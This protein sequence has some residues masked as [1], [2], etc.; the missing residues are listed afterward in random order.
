MATKI[1]AHNLHTDVK[2]ILDSKATTTQL[3]AKADISALAG[4]ADSDTVVAALANKLTA[5]EE[6]TFFGLRTRVAEAMMFDNSI[7][8]SGPYEY[9]DQQISHGI[10]DSAFDLI[11]YNMGDFQQGRGGNV[12]F[13]HPAA[14]YGATGKTH[15][16]IDKNDDFAVVTSGHVRLVEDSRSITLGADSDFTIT[17]DGTNNIINSIGPGDL[18]IQDAGVSKLALDASGIIVYG[19][20][21][22]VGD[23][24]VTGAI[25]STASG[26][27]TITSASNIIFNADSGN[28][29][30]NFSGSKIIN[31]ANPIDSQDAA[32][33]SYV[34]SANY[35]DSDVDT[36]LN[37][38][39]AT[40][41]E[42][43]SWSGTDYNWV[44]QSGGASGGSTTVNTIYVD[45]DIKML[46]TGAILTITPSGSGVDPYTGQTVTWPEQNRFEK[47]VETLSWGAG[48]YAMFFH[49]MI[50]PVPIYSNTN[51]LLSADIT[52]HIATYGINSANSGYDSDFADSQ[53]IQGHLMHNHTTATFT[54]TSNV[55]TDPGVNLINLST[56]ISS[57]GVSLDFQMAQEKLTR[58]TVHS[59]AAMQLNNV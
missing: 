45:S 51:K 19:S 14:G 7:W 38:S 11:F 15:L 36:H 52:I 35:K 3:A 9:F 22:V 30:I 49:G 5:V 55:C 1:K 12:R 50:N 16:L 47:K 2:A 24:T 40:V 41:G 23:V 33:K 6:Y 37:T 44:S 10:K 29:I 32:S 48:L 54:Q 27:P 13:T 34:D 4:K 42:V 21:R 25:Q 58:Y 18:F 53:I 8:F 20:H 46:D 59:R 26:T 17:H 39:T 56:S 43:L 57:G 31:I 28:G